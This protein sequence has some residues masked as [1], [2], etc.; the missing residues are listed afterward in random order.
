MQI[1]YIFYSYR[2]FVYKTKIEFSTI[3]FFKMLVSVSFIFVLASCDKLEIQQD[4]HSYSQQ[5]HLDPDDLTFPTKTQGQNGI[6]LRQWLSARRSL[7]ESISTVLP[8]N[9]RVVSRFGYRISPHTRQL[10]LHEGLDI[11]A[12]YGTPVKATESGVI[13]YAAYA[14]GYGKLVS[15][16]H[17]YGLVTRYAHNSRV[18]V[19]KG[20]RV[21]RGEII[22]SVGNTGRTTGPHLHYEIRL[23]GEAINIEDLTF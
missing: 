23:N 11:A 12:P 21:I 3:I 6:R 1:I 2:S 19:E 14:A 4:I 7:L 18:F 9:G 8:L 16:N 20:Q 5:L 17:G 13:I 15:I 22:A 10:S